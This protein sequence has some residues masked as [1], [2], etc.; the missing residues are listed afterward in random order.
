MPVL[1]GVG[2]REDKEWGENGIIL[3]KARRFF[4]SS[5]KSIYVDLLDIL[6]VI[7]IVVLLILLLLSV[8]LEVHW[9]CGLENKR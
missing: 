1:F 3:T 7:V 9:V 4:L 5:T 2:R 8:Q 6:I